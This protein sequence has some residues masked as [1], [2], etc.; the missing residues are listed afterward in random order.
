MGLALENFDGGGQY[1][2]M[3]EG[4]PI[5]ASG[6]LDGT[7]FTDVEGLSKALHDHPQVPRCLVRRVYSYGTGGPLTND[8][9]DQ[10]DALTK[11]FAASGYRVPD[12]MR[13]IA[14]SDAF[15]RVSDVEVPKATASAAAHPA[16][17]AH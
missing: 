10:V 15:I 3:E 8:S 7:T 13:A 5:D 17:A 14:L 6:N 4:V 11:V 2:T 1:R 9:N 16:P 12:L